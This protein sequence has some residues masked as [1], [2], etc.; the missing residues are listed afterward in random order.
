MYKKLFILAALLLLPVEALADNVTIDFTTSPT[1]K[2]VEYLGDL[3]GM[4]GNVLVGGGNSLLASLFGIFNTTVLSLGGVVLMYTTVMSTINTAHEGEVMGKKWSSIWIPIKSAASVSLLLPTSN[5]YSLIQVMV[6]SIVLQSINAANQL[7]DRTIDFVLTG[8]SINKIEAPADISNSS[9]STVQKN[10]IESLFKSTVCVSMLNDV[11]KHRNLINHDFAQC[12]QNGNSISCGVQGSSSKASICG[13]YNPVTS[14]GGIPSSLDAGT[15]SSVQLTA[16][17]TA[18]N[19][20][21]NFSDQAVM[22]YLK[23]AETGELD[24]VYNNDEQKAINWTGYNI[25]NNAYSSFQSIMSNLRVPASSGEEYDMLTRAK[26]DGWIFAGVYY[27]KLAKPQQEATAITA[28]P[29]QDS[30]SPIASSTTNNFSSEVTAATDAYKK[31]SN[32]AKTAASTMAGVDVSGGS[33]NP[34]AFISQAVAALIF[35][36]I[37]DIV[38]ISDGEDPMIS[39]QRSG[40]SILIAVETTFFITLGVITIYLFASG[41]CSA[42]NPLPIVNRGILPVIMPFFLGLLTI[43]WAGGA[44]LALYLPLIPYMTFTF[45]AINW[46]VS[47]LEAMIASPIVAL[48]L[49]APGGDYLGKASPAVLLLTNVFLRPALMVLGFILGS[50]LFVVAIK[51][52]VFSFKTTATLQVF[53][54]T[55]SGPGAFGPIILIMIFVGAAMAITNTSFSLIYLL[56]DKV[57]RWIGGHAEQSTVA[58]DMHK[59]KQGFDSSAQTG[60]QAVAA[61]A[62]KLGDAKDKKDDKD[63]KAQAN[64]EQ[65][66]REKRIDAKLDALEQRTGGMRT[67]ATNR[68]F[69]AADAT[70]GSNTGPTM[71]QK[72]KK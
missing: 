46:F 69:G 41:T 61:A 66:E 7:W 21:Q 59:A 44:S 12:Y 49:A 30:S 14:G 27:Y 60:Q 25:I 51:M 56:P 52:L 17:L 65:K 35:A 36:I 57:I 71:S 9:T 26:E 5:G 22:Q 58:S 33:G 68:I 3:F 63:A 47:V 45:G 54:S 64:S 6:M 50:R 34:F 55:A 39:M 31:F 37:D 70:T 8:Q 32:Q 24:Y 67:G 15:V 18:L 4:V 11:E 19:Y 48:G 13:K 42:A 43:L 53:N 10:F 38:D 2:S 40:N 1:D 29:G 62:T 28:T 72:D 23:N 20:L 16:T